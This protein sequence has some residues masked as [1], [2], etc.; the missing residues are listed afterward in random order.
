[1]CMSQFACGR[2]HIVETFTKPLTESIQ[3]FVIVIPCMK[4]QSRFCA[5]WRQQSHKHSLLISVR[6]FCYILVHFGH[7]IVL[8]AELTWLCIQPAH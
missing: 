1:M 8:D 4:Q 7:F 6:E 5:E 2:N 3:M